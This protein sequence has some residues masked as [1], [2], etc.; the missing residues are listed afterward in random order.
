MKDN[1]FRDLSRGEVCWIFAFCINPV[2]ALLAMGI[3]YIASKFRRS[4]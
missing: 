1:T 3:I 4:Q 2:C